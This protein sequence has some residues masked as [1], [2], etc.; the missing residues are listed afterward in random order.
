MEILSDKLVKTR[1][2]HWCSACS[3]TF[4]KGTMMQTQVNTYGGIG[5]W[6]TCPTCTE[7]LSKF[8]DEFKDSGEFIFE[9]NCVCDSANQYETPEMMLERLKKPLPEPTHH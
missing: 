7:L 5:V 9:G 3:R 8:P 1:K 4:P 2:V 6:R